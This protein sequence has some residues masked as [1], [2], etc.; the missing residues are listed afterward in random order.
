MLIQP[1]RLPAPKSLR[2][3]EIPDRTQPALEGGV[4]G[5]NI[6]AAQLLAPD[7]G[8]K[9][10][11]PPWDRMGLGDHIE[12]LLDGIQVDQTTL[13]KPGDVGER[14]TLYVP[15]QKFVTG[16]Y[17]LQYRVKV[18]EQTPETSLPPVN[19]FV[20]LDRPGGK[21][22]NGSAPG[23]SELYM[24][25]D[26]RI[27]NDGVDKETAETGLDII[28]QA[29]PGS[30]S[31][32][33]Y[34]NMAVGDRCKLTWG[35][36]FVYSP[37]VTQD[38]IDDP[39]GHPLV[40][41]VDKA[42]ILEAGDTDSLAVAFEV[43]DIVDN[44]SE[45]WC[46]AVEI[47]VDT[48][49]TRLSPPM[50]KEA[51]NSIVD[52]DKL[53]DAPLTLQVVVDAP[54]FRIG[55]VIIGLGKGTTLDGE[56][57]SVEVRGEPL[58]S[59]GNIYELALPSADIRLLAK[60]QAVFSYRVERSGSDDR[61]S[62]GRFVRII[63]ATRRLLAP[64]AVD[65]QQ[66][67]LD[68]DRVY[69]TAVIPF[70]PMMQ[71]GMV[72]V[73]RWVG[74]RQDF[75]V[76]DPELD[77]HTLSKGDID[78]K[79]P[80]PIIVEGKHL[81][82]IEGG[83]L[84]LFYVLMAEGNDGGIIQ[85]ESLHHALLRVGEPLLELVAP[86][87]LGEAGGTLEPDDLPGGSSKLTAPAA[88]EPTKA[89]DKVTYTWRGSKTGKTSDSVPI[90]SLNAGKAID[91][92]LNPTFVQTHIEP[93][94]G[95]TVDAM[96]EI[97]RVAA[98]S[99]PE[100][101]SYSR[102]LNFTVGEA[103]LLTR[104]K[105]QQAEADGTTLQP[106]KA[107]EALTVNIDSQDLLPSDLLSVTWTGA[108]GTAA[109]GSYTTPAK[110]ISETT[111]TI[112]LPVTVLA[113]NLGKTVTVTYTVTRNGVPR[114]S[115]PL[116]LNVGTF[117]D[118]SL[119]SPVIME[120]DN[121]G[122]GPEF[123]VA[124]LTANAVARIDV[125]PLI[126]TG[127]RMWMRL[128]GT[129]ANDT[130]YI[131][132]IAPGDP[133]TQ[134]LIDRGYQNRGLTQAAMKNLK[135]GSDL[136]IECKTT[137]NKSTN[138]SEAVPFPV[139]TYTIKAVEDVRPD[140]TR[141]EDS[142]GNEIL[143]GATTVDTSITLKGK[144]A[145]GQKVLIKDGTTV[146]G[147]ADVDPQSGDW[148]FPVTGLSADTHS[149]TAT[150]RYGNEEVSLPRIVVVV[151]ADIPA[152]TSVKDESN[153]NIRENGYTVHTSVTF[154]GFAPA[155]QEVEVF[156]GAV[157]KG[158]AKAESNSI[159]TRT[160]SGLSL[161]VLHT[162]KAI[163]QYANNP[164]SN[165]WRLTVL[166][167]VRPAITGAEDSKGQP[168]SNDGSTGD[169]TVRLRGTATKYLEVEIFDGNSS[170]GKK[171]LANE[172]G[173]W[174]VELTGLTRT[175]HVFKAKALYGSGTES[176]EWIV[177]VAD[178]VDLVEDFK[179][180]PQ[181]VFLKNPGQSIEGTNTKVTLNATLGGSKDHMV[182]VL[183]NT[184]L[185]RAI[186]N[187]DTSQNIL[188]YSL[189]LKQG[190]AKSA[191]LNGRYSGVPSKV[192]HIKLE[193]RQNDLV[194]DSIV[195][196]EEPGDGYWIPIDRELAPLNGQAFN[197]LKFEFTMLTSWEHMTWFDILKVTFKS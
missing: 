175:R 137:F 11:C 181:G 3:L 21:D 51:F 27:I 56:P 105:V 163:G 187:T 38:H 180:Y 92:T 121:D 126:A 182:V 8:L 101:V 94:R 42:T 133:V 46:A 30:S 14:V 33:P 189:A 173:I 52:M 194:V 7:K 123:N 18:F 170:T 117:S 146:K 178:L 184:P 197:T 58:T 162:F 23:H 161:D 140:I 157:S 36:W 45:D 116:L 41:H 159:W 174:T 93:N 89:G 134:P 142:K 47:A 62:S 103:V 111:L 118:S 136:T 87:V 80:I 88:A 68:P 191:I 171:A 168:I 195:L 125:W 152:I 95:G 85:R 113:F 149:F 13:V 53:G 17:T 148:E 54:E 82:A 127:Q 76:Y 186:S 160:V 49:N 179:S 65:A 15:P 19:I 71:E 77:W 143:P 164:P 104:P 73:L 155:G 192:G 114:T 39:Q 172:N 147:T 99:T 145:K 63:G 26:P 91:F 59:V 138:E 83:T 106:I 124:N 144:G 57:I 32:L 84:D 50:V 61:A 135:D 64:I 119:K 141:V 44:R 97:L 177:T 35:G 12:L 128:T 185:L 75:G 188:A 66:G 34:P 10:Y 40:I 190:S 31:P 167:G 153:W 166:N 90:N 1:P 102:T 70:D 43:H 79:E 55:D 22:E 130:P 158:K 131:N 107:V 156:L 176:G 100:R 6:A 2:Q 122:E 151:A 110:P 60:T 96:Y 183:E 150:A 169:T 20:K 29:K 74:T 139:R 5:I 78:D 67:A 109:G 24:Y 69:T 98:G 196:F 16:A 37:R 193:F 9:V 48:G 115:L 132:D 112:E 81:K 120:A 108:P 4:W 72:I 25:I 129:N 28:I 86:I 154:T 165:T